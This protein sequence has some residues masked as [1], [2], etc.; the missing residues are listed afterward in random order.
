MSWRSDFTRLGREILIL[1]SNYDA[2]FSNSN[3]NSLSTMAS[4]SLFG[5]R[6]CLNYLVGL[7]DKILRQLYNVFQYVLQHQSIDG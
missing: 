3:V 4:N 6:R 2:L 7:Q 5:T 1:A